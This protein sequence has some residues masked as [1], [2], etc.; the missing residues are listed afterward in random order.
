MNYS[1]NIIKYGIYNVIWVLNVLEILD[2]G[3]GWI[4]REYRTKAK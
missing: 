2:V 1:E 4:L 3:V